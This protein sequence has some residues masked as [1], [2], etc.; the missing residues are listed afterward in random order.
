MNESVDLLPFSGGPLIGR[1]RRALA[2]LC[3]L[4]RSGAALVLG[5]TLIL[6]PKTVLAEFGYNQG[7]ASQDSDVLIEQLLGVCVDAKG[8]EG[9]RRGGGGV[10]GRCPHVS[11]D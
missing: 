6:E 10:E 2:A 7:K 9:G 5:A 3:L 8:G 4:T 1:K 11:D